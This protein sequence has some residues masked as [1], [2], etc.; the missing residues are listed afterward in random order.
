[1]QPRSFAK[2]NGSSFKD[3]KFHEV[4]DSSA[5]QM[6]VM[7]LNKWKCGHI[8]TNECKK[9]DDKTEIRREWL[10]YQEMSS[11]L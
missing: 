10:E 5:G 1:M 6:Y 4:F 2:G 7:P 9:H 3:T 8:R 11:T